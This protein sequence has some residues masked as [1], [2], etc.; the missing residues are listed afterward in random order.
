M[1]RS[2]PTLR[3]RRIAISAIGLAAILPQAASAA[4]APP[5][6]PAVT[7]SAIYDGEAL[8]NATGGL[9]T[10]VV[11][12]GTLRLPV[13]VDGERLLG[14]RGMTFYAEGLAVHGGEPERWV[15][16]AQGVS[17]LAAP[18]GAQLYEAWVQQN[19]AENRVSLL[20]GRYD[21]NSELY[22]LQTAGLFLNSSFGLGPEFSQSGAGGPSIYPDAAVGARLAVKPA[23]GVV[24]RAAVLDGAPVERPGEGARLF[25]KG[26]GEL[27]VAEAAFLRRQL[28]EDRP[29]GGP[30]S[31]RFRIGRNSG[32]SPYDGKLAV[33]GWYYTASFDDLSA[34]G[35]AGAPLRHRGSGGVYGLADAPLYQS[36]TQ[37]ARQVHA[38]LQAGL[39]DSRVD[40]FGSYAGAGLAISG[41][42]PAL[43]GDELGLAVALARNGSHFLDQQRQDAVPVSGTETALELTWLL[44]VGK[45]L[46][47]QPDLQYILHPGTDPTRRNALAVALR[48][49]LS[50]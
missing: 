9:R 41:L 23:P 40:R 22:R 1:D 2:R 16:D 10:G 18:G 38:F 25:A 11:Y 44:Q 12:L 42:L 19:L 33:G 17:N 26:D 45:H 14:W 49:E 35:P 43:A 13:T 3:W 28:P 8:W 27:L 48:F 4:D 37:S 5:A 7:C 6:P 29:D 34:R 50:D 20:V 36:A 24:L 21:V 15:G 31:N 46:A 30:R 32:L 47:L 39:G